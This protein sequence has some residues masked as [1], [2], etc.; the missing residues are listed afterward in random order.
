M[1]RHLFTIALIIYMNAVC[2]GQESP[3][4]K[5]LLKELACGTCHS[6]ISIK[7]DI[8]E[9]AP[10]LTLA[11]I[12]YNPEYILNYLQHPVRVR[13]H[14]GLSRMPDFHLSEK[15]AL[16]LTLYL[17]ELIPEE[18]ERP[19]F[20]VSKS[21]EKIR[22]SYPE[23][24]ARAGKESFYGLN[25]VAC[26]QQSSI[27]LW[28]DKMAPDLSFEGDRVKKE[29]LVNY[30]QAPTPLR[31]FGYYPGSG[32]R[33]PDFMLSD[34]E[35]EIL[36][37]YLLKQK[38]D[39][40]AD[41]LSFEPQELSAY[42][43]VKAE[44]LMKEKLSCLGCHQLGGEGGK[45][46]PDLSS[47]NSR[48]Q[49]NYVYQIVKNPQRL[50][51]E[52]IMPRIQMPDKHLDL[53]VNYLVR[54]NLPRSEANYLSLTENPPHFYQE[55]ENGPRLYTKYCASCHGNR[56][57]GDGYN[58]KYLPVNP[59]KHAD[60]SYMKKRPDDTLFDGIYA[61]GYILNKSHLMPPWGYTLEYSEIRTLVSYL[62][63]LCGCKGPEWSRDD[64]KDFNQR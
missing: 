44:K 4:A 42:N 36:A 53:I 46:G 6:G 33:M 43:M 9:K 12:R 52:G 37:D 38:K 61:G 30:L 62:R 63:E 20:P 27:M 19:D 39:W 48:L 21:Y 11:G 54:Q 35:A 32:T 8:T 14:I 49:E 25:C 56:G 3:T 22:S 51:P 13:Q 2:V 7:T 60:A 10:D 45:I 55:L 50:I 41:S 47:L 26:H 17:E 40:N 57:N 64:L 1:L 29:W 5:Q 23:I 15:E 34:K 16:A 59:T 18:M 24:D 31:P 28:E 58:A